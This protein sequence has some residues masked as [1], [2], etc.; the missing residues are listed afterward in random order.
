MRM[1]PRQRGV[2][3]IEMMVVVAILAIMAALAAPQM[4][5]ITKKLRLAGEA[6]AVASFLDTVR[7][8]AMAVNRCY[9]V[10]VINVAV[11]TPTLTVEERNSGDCA[12]GHLTVDGWTQKKSHIPEKG[13]RLDSNLPT[14][15][16]LC[17]SDTTAAT[18]IVFRPS[19]RLRGT[20]T[21]DPTQGRARIRVSLF[22]GL[23]GEEKDVIIM[24]SGRICVVSVTGFDA[25][26][27]T[28]A[29][30]TAMATASNLND[31][32]LAIP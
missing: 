26:Y 24:Q 6:E 8:R 27:S 28:T 2:S 22:S 5:P 15:C 11:N 1:I 12:T 14:N 23:P 29:P 32:T 18:A 4:L 7:R 10:Q 30:P 20:N 16:H 13:T 25:T 17:G 19:G 31:C 3:L 21:L 9:R